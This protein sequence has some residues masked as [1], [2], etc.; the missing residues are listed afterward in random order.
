MHRCSQALLLQL[1]AALNTDSIQCF[2]VRIYFS[3]VDALLSL[4]VIYF[5]LLL[6]LYDSAG[7]LFPRGGATKSMF[8]EENEP[9][10]RFINSGCLMGRAGQMRQLLQRF[11]QGEAYDIYR[12]DQQ[13]LALTFLQSPHLISLDIDNSFM[14]TGY[15]AIREFQYDQIQLFNNFSF[16]F[17]P[18]AHGVGVAHFNAKHREQSY[19]RFN[20][21]VFYLRFLIGHYAFSCIFPVS[22]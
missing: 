6:F 7:P 18:F 4:I 12:D 21:S 15:K 22:F 9:R 16:S 5:H 3:F 10:P 14:V 1:S 13:Q 19:N 11:R 8:N 2:K 20:F 17:G